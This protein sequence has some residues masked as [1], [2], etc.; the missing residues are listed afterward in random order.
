[1]VP[2]V[3]LCTVSGSVITLQ[4]LLFLWTCF[5]QWQFLR[6]HCSYKEEAE[7]LLYSPGTWYI[8][9][10]A[11][12]MNA[13]FAL[14]EHCSPYCVGTCSSLQYSFETSDKFILMNFNHLKW[15]TCVNM[16]GHRPS[17]A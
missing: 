1:M 9:G 15:H 12:A 14:H 3:C 4:Y 5:W 8:F 13:L 10:R 17:G 2:I 7:Q 11:K 6:F 16:K